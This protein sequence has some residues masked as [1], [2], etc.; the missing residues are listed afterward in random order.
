MS[1]GREF[2]WRG[3]GVQS[4]QRPPMRAAAPSLPPRAGGEGQATDGETATHTLVRDSGP[5]IGR[6]LRPHGWGPA[7]PSL[8][9]NETKRGVLCLRTTMLSACAGASAVRM[10][11]TDGFRPCAFGSAALRLFCSRQIS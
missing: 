11:T 3:Q 10:A 1:V 4:P 9:Q 6:S 5:P 2:T 7:A 8:M